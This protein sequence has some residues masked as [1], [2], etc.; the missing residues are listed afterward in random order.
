[1]KQKIF[2][3]LFLVSCL[4]VNAQFSFE[5][6]YAWNAL[7][8]PKTFGKKLQLSF[9]RTEDGFPNYGTVMAGGTY[10]TNQ[11]GSVFQLYFPYSETLGGNA[12]KV[13]LGLHNNQGWSNWETFFTTANANTTDIDWK[14]K[15]LILSDDITTDGRISL[16]SSSLITGDMI[17]L[18]GNRLNATTMYGFGVEAGAIYTKTP[19][20]HRWYIGKNA[21]LGVST[22]MELSNTMLYVADKIGIGTKDT[23]GY[24]LAVAG[25]IVTEEVKVALQTSWPD[26]VF[27]KEYQLTTLKEV[28]T[29]IKEKGHLKDIPSEEE[30]SKDGISLG[31]M[32]AKLLQKIEELTLYVIEQNKEIDTLKKQRESDVLIANTLEKIQEEIEQLKRK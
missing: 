32:N 8:E 2:T 18:Y 17:S 22:K 24:A 15:K 21:D 11:D 12:P 16:R 14:A 1:M 3:L 10:A 4:T 27:K 30:V 29:Y 31:E 9:V 19:N 7:N 6:N 25:K 28:E 5:A 20:F 26:Y 13:R 23:K